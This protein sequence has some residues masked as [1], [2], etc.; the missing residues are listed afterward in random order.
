MFGNRWVDART[1]P[2]PDFGER[3]VETY[4]LDAGRT[5]TAPHS[6]NDGALATDALEASS[7]SDTLPWRLHNPCH[8]GTDEEG[9][10]GLISATGQN[11]CIDDSRTFEAGALAY[12]TPPFDE[13][14]NIAGPISASLFASTTSTNTSWAVVLSDVAPDGSST[15]IS[16]GQLLGSLRALDE[17]RT[18]YFDGD[19]ETPGNQPDLPDPT[20]GTPAT[21]RTE[22]GRRGLDDGKLIRPLHPYTRESEEPVEPGA[23][24]R[25]DILL[26]PVFARI[27]SGHRLRF[28]I[29]TNASWAQPFAKDHGDVAGIYQVRRNKQDASFL[30]VPFVSG[31]IPESSTDWVPVPPTA[32][33]A[34]VLGQCY[35]N[36]EQQTEGK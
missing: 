7:E 31:P 23:V 20:Q 3:R 27:R 29:R 2:L 11:P 5:G 28:A 6:L 35:P 16:K 8:Q 22:R 10:F 1:W 24:E 21:E 19:G 12:T 13:G 15:L 34:D 17:D 25:Y 30:N 14:R 9:T 18:W 33:R 26:D 36:L 32:D 4:Y